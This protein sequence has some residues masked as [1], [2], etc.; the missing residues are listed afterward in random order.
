[1]AAQ[2]QKS[3]SDFIGRLMGAVKRKPKPYAQV[4]EAQRKAKA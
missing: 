3:L 2:P 1:M 4:R